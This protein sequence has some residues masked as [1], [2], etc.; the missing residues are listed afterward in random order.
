MEGGKTMTTRYTGN[1]VLRWTDNGKLR[2][3]VYANHDDA[4]KALKWLESNG[5]SDG[6][7]AVQ[8]QNIKVAEPR[9]YADS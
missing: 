5:C 6:D 3:K 9:Q 2:T 1:Y 8:T 7:I 4:K